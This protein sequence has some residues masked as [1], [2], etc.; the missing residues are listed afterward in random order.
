MTFPGFERCVEFI[1]SDSQAVHE[2][3]YF[4]LIDR[5]HRHVDELIKLA[6]EEEDDFVRVTW[7]ELLGETRS[8]DAIP[9][10]KRMLNDHNRTVRNYAAESL[11]KLSLSDNGGCG[12]VI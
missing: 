11:K 5:A 2:D 8:C 12:E 1:R 7:V 9:T 10:L 3:G 6:F 4:W